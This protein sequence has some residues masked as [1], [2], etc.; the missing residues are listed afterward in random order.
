[1]NKQLSLRDFS[2]FIAIVAIWAFFAIISP[3]YL[4][5]RNLSMLSIE[6]S[7]TA[8]AALGVLL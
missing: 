7:T 2:L 8:V 1:M 3:S 5:A 4:G 6:M